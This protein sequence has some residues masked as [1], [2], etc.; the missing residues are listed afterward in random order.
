MALT[1]ISFQI[2]LFKVTKNLYKELL[3][4]VFLRQKKMAIPEY[5]LNN[6]S[7]TKKN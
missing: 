6:P 4:V 3:L 7:D 2:M 1:F 5:V